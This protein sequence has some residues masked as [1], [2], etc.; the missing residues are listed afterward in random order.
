M[1]SVLGGDGVAV[2]VSRDNAC[3]PFFVGIQN[4][5]IFRDCPD[6]GEITPE[7]SESQFVTYFY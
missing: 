3:V 1:S 4:G 2:A 5:S 7:G 6:P